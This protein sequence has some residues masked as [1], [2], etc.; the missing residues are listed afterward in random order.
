MDIKH[1]I[2]GFKVRGDKNY[3]DENVSKHGIAGLV[4]ILRSDVNNV[5]DSASQKPFRYLERP[6]HNFQFGYTGAT[7]PFHCILGS[8]TNIIVE[9]EQ[10][11]SLKVPGE[12]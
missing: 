3:V 10:K 4:L 7:C 1:E 9:S 11:A 6:F 2:I 5:F 12:I 8:T